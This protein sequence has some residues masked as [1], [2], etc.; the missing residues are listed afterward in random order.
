MMTRKPN[1]LLVVYDSARAKNFSIYGYHRATTPFLEEFSQNSAIYTNAISTVASTVPAHASIFTGTI[2]YTHQLFLDGDRLSDKYLTLADVLKESG[3]NTYGLCYQDDV[4][5]LTGLDR[6][7]IEFDKDDMPNMYKKFLRKIFHSKNPFK[8]PN[9]SNPS[10]VIPIPGRCVG[11]KTIGSKPP[12]W[13]HDILRW[14]YWHATQFSDQ[15]AASTQKKVI[16]FLDRVD[17]NAP[18]FMYLHYDET[19][20]PYR[21]P[22][23]Y[24]NQF[25]HDA[26]DGKKPWKVN[27]LRNHFFLNKVEMN[28]GDFDVLRNLYDGAIRYLDE[29][30]RELIRIFES[31]GLLDDTMVIIMGDHGDNIGEHQLMSHKWCLYDTLIRVPLIIKYPR[32]I[33]VKGKFDGIVQHTDI[34]PTVLDVL[35]IGNH[36]IIRQLE[37]NS[38]IS[39]RFN[40]RDETYA[41]SEQFKPFGLD[42]RDHS[43]KLKKYD[44]RLLSLRTLN[45]KYIWGSDGL[46][47]FYDIANDPEEERNL[48][49]S[50]IPEIEKIRLL[51]EPHLGKHNICYERLKHAL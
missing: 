19:H 47:E 30:T 40:N 4:S 42:M 10:G 45:Y 43:E 21:P 26:S 44:R 14:L 23:P 9:P 13:E 51:L 41:I 2:V 46:D 25:F 32:S 48:I 28:S 29:K 11:G 18:F 31:R 36:P 1:I 5:P 20:L 50:G 35:R 15:G 34:V 12:I 39:H 17:K 6:G 49:A 33:E 16:R 22:T 37:G 3:Y 24:R 8:I 7:F 27:Q 38:L